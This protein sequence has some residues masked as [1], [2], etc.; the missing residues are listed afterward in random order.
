MKY[1]YAYE[2]GDVLAERAVERLEESEIFKGKD[3]A[4]LLPIPIH[5][6]RRK[7]RG[8]NQTELIGKLIAKKMRWQYRDDILEKIRFT[9]PQTGLERRVRLR[10]QR[11]SFSVIGLKG[12]DKNK[13]IFLFDDIC[14]TGA[15][16][17][18]AAKELKRKGLKNV[19][20]LSVAK[21]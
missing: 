20:G 2:M 11:N 15:T 4:Y 9:V 16:I 17:K 18:E 7:I 3:N 10:N 19:W 21:T 14:T 13:T 1:K 8:F 5:K 6:R 12:T